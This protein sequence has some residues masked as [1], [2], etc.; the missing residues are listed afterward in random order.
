MSKM[1]NVYPSKR[2]MNLAMREK[3]QTNRPLAV[4]AVLLVIA[5]IGVFYL[6]AVRRV[7]D[8]VDSAAT[9]A[10]KR[11]SVDVISGYAT[12]SE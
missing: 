12:S 5:F 10:D 8:E 7:L 3:P 6:F 9:A 2:D 1:R 4:L 11:P